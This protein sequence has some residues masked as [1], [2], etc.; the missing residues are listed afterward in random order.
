MCSTSFFV[1][2]FVHVSSFILFIKLLCYYVLCFFVLLS[3]A[4]TLFFCDG[5]QYNKKK[6]GD[7]DGH[8]S[9]RNCLL[10]QVTGGKR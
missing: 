5:A 4:S 7:M 2:I 9:R 3:P 10:R 1:I 8:I 6:E